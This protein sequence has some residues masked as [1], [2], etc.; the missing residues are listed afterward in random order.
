MAVRPFRAADASALVAIAAECARSENDFVLSPLWETE[1]DLFAEFDRHS[2]DPEEHM[3][4][5]ETA[6][7]QVVGC[8]G[9][10]RRPRDT[11][12]GLISPVVARSERGCG[13][14]GALL[15]SVLALGVERLGVKLVSAGIGTRNRMGYSLLASAGFRPVRQYFLLRATRRPQVPSPPRGLAFAPATREDATEILALYHAC[16]FEERTLEGMREIL[17]DRRHAHAVARQDGRTV[18]FTELET[19][20]PDRP[21]VAFVGVQSG[22]RDRGVGSALVAWAV[23]KQFDAGARAAL[24]LLS[25]ANRTARRAY[26]KAGFRRHRVIDVLEK[27]L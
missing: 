26:E 18:A 13:Y 14:G 27:A 20:W 9:F 5:A 16:G 4:V 24:L 11:L 2:I 21:W 8:A 17:N 6:G 1:T 3:R 7:G 15:R 23:A 22:L 10:A 19:H 12:A 25:P